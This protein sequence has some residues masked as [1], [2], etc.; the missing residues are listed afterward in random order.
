MFNSK[1]RHVDF[2]THGGTGHDGDHDVGRLRMGLL[3]LGLLVLGLLAVLAGA[4]ISVILE[5][6]RNVSSASPTGDEALEVLRRRFAEGDID[7]DEYMRRLS[8]ISRR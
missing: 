4:V 6:R 3:V 5:G 7:E 2:S 1:E 8:F